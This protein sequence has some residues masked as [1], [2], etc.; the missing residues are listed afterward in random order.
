MQTVCLDVGNTRMKV[1][2]FQPNTEAEYLVFDNYDLDTIIHLQQQYV[3]SKFVLSSTAQLDEQFIQQLKKSSSFLEINHQTEL[4][5][6]NLYKTPNTLGEDRVAAVAG[7]ISLYPQRNCLIIDAGTCITLDFINS[8]REYLG[9]S[10]HPGVEMRLKAM[11]TFTDK[12]PLAEKKWSDSMIGGTTNECL[13]VGA[14]RGAVIEIDSFISEY[15]KSHSDIVVI[16]TGGDSDLFFYNLKNKIFA[17]PNL[18]LIGL[19]KIA[20]NNA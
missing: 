16:I 19:H 4:P 13:T 18:V 11:H 17:H 5:F 15:Q 8:D 20:Q 12:L 7:A 10:I 9:G 1:G 6:K 3:D 2:I 14:V